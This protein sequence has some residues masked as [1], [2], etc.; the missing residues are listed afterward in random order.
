[1][2]FKN[3]NLII[4]QSPFQVKLF[5]EYNDDIFVDGTF[6]LFPLNLVIKYFLQELILK[7]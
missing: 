1:M 7:N 2:I 6:F 4:F 3:F 5:K